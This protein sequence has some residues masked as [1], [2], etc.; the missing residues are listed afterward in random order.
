MQSK[1]QKNIVFS[2]YNNYFLLSG[3]EIP[4]TYEP[5]SDEQ[6]PVLRKAT[7]TIVNAGG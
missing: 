6:D 7:Y 1:N 2:Y 4:F 5:R 3:I